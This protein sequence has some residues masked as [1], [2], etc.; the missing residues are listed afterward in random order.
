MGNHGKESKGMGMVE[1]IGEK[2][3]LA[4]VRLGIN[5]VSTV[6][7]PLPAT[8]RLKVQN[9]QMKGMITVEA[10]LKNIFVNN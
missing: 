7:P 3:K 5:W 6:W 2:K 1:E 4:R 10:Y 9:L 8:R